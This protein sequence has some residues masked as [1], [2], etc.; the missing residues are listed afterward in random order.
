[1]HSSKLLSLHQCLTG[2]QPPCKS[3]SRRRSLRLCGG[4]HNAVVRTQVIGICRGC[5]LSSMA[6][7]RCQQHTD[8]TASAPSLDMRL[9]AAAADGAPCACAAA[10][11]TLSCCCRGRS[12]RGSTKS[13]STAGHGPFWLGLAAPCG[14]EPAIAHTYLMFSFQLWAAAGA[15]AMTALQV[16]V[17]HEHAHDHAAAETGTHARL[18]GGRAAL[19][20]TRQA[21]AKVLPLPG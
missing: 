6:G 21:G 4:H 13:R 9:H 5:A 3:G 2:H 1:M 12:R 15:A 8:L 20:P 18:R 19:D 7:Q 16:A 17:P 11:T 14:R 10:A